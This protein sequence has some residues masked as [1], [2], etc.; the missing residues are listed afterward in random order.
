MGSQNI[1][2]PDVFGGWA[3]QNIGKAHVLRRRAFVL[4]GD[5]HLEA[6]TCRTIEK[7]VGPWGGG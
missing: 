4:Q 3:S 1:G 6:G 2:L 5:L 7:E